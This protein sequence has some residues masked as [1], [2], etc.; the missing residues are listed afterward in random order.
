SSW[1]GR[2]FCGTLPARKTPLR[3]EFPGCRW[4]RCDSIAGAGTTRDVWKC[5]NAT[6]ATGRCFE[7]GGPWVAQSFRLIEDYMNKSLWTIV[8]VAV[9]GTRVW[10]QDFQVG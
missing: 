2:R 7:S 10:A 9:L 4:D 6:F 8:M 5:R 3:F 1:K